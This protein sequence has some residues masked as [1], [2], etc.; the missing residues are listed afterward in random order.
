MNEVNCVLD[1]SKFKEQI[2]RTISKAEIIS[3]HKYN[4]QYGQSNQSNITNNKI[5]KIPGV[6]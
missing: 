6:V 3:K 4:Q 2:V 1:R 5:R